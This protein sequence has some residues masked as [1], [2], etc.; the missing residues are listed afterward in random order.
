M[1]KK[2]I[3][4]KRNEGVSNRQGKRSDSDLGYLIETEE[5]EQGTMVMFLFGSQQ[6]LRQGRAKK[7]VC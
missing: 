5:S 4:T 6:Y 1:N 3:E 7:R 2:E